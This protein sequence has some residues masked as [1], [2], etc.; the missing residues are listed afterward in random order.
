MGRLFSGSAVIIPPTAAA[1]MELIRKSNVKLYGKEVVIVGHS[2]IAGKPLAILLLNEFATVSVCHIATYETKNLKAHVNKAEILVV[3][4]GKPNLIKGEWI[5]KGAIVIDIGIN[6][7]GDKIVG[8]VEFTKA[9]E[10]ASYISP[11][12]GGVGPVTTAMLMKNCIN[13]FK[14]QRGLL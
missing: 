10:K 6:K 5:R 9:S 8:D 2:D 11:V 7:L 12:P 14:L 4:V 13:L 1:A 3:A